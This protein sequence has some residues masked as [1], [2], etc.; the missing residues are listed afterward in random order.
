MRK[1][2]IDSL[3]NLKII[4]RAGAGV[5]NVDVE[6]A[7]NKK[8]Y[9]NEY[10]RRKYKCYSRTHNWFNFALQRKLLLPMRQLIRVL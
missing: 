9:R 10:S 8:Y 3:S 2:L 5:D 1:D 4:G 7:K 6:A